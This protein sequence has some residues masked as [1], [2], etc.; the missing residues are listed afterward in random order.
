MGKNSLIAFCPYCGS[1]DVGIKYSW[2]EWDDQEGDVKVR[3]TDYDR[4][5][6]HHCGN[7]FRVVFV[8]NARTSDDD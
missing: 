8:S 1:K 2:D 6:C 3:R 7:I 5:I 4:F